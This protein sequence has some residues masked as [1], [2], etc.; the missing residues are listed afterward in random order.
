[1]AAGDVETWE[2]SEMFKHKDSLSSTLALV[3]DNEFIYLPCPPAWPNKIKFGHWQT[4]HH[5]RTPE[6]R[7]CELCVGT[8]VRTAHRK[9]RRIYSPLLC[10]L[11]HVL[12]DVLLTLLLLFNI[13]TPQT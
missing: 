9:G 5:G 10:V 2:D 8:P 6:D 4:A 11:I 1:M 3:L 12:K 7:V 13:Q